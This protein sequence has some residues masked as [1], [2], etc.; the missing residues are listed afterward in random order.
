MQI[1][2]KG[3]NVPVTDEMRK[4]VTRGLE[5]VAKQVS[6]LAR[7][8]LELHRERNPSIADSEVAEAILHLKGVTL[9]VRE[10]SPDMQR[11]LNLVVEELSRQVKRHRVKRRRRREQ[12]AA[13][14]RADRQ[15]RPLVRPSAA[16]QPAG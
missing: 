13:A 4:R 6:P 12:H 14:L 2:I 3:R 7:A 1:D 15:L 10:S 16:A 9:R 5:K 11:S 8:E